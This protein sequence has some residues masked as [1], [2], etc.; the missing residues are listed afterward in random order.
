MAEEI[1]CPE[2]NPDS[3]KEKETTL[4]DRFFI[5]KQVRTFNF[6]P[7]NFGS[8]MTKAIEQIESFGATVV[9]NMVLSEHVGR[10]K[11]EVFIAVEKEIPELK[12]FKMHGTFLAN[13][14]EGPFRDTGIWTKEFER[15]AKNKEFPIGRW[16][17]WY[18]TCPR[19]AKKYGKN[20]VVILGQKA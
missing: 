8:V 4:D 17:M 2:F 14:Y 16:F 10:W 3:W 9:E 6:M 12:T 15:I 5:K 11:M 20:Y 13:V 18:T 1:C 7:L 19:C